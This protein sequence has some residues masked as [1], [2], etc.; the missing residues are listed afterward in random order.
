MRKVAIIGAG[1]SP[2]GVFPD[3]GVKELGEEACWKAIKDANIDPRRIEIAYCGNFCGGITDKQGGV[4]GQIV[5]AQ[6]GITGI[7]ITRVENACASSSCALREAYLVIAGGFYDIAIAFGVEK[8]TNV[9]TSDA[10]RGL[11]SSSDVELEGDMG[12]TFPGVFSL[13]ARRHMHQYGTTREQLAKVAIKN[14][15]NGSLNPYAQFQ[16]EI[17]MEQVLQ[18][19]MIADPLTLFDCCPISD[20]CTAVILAGEDTAKKISD[21]PVWIAASVLATGKYLNDSDIT[22]FEL[23]KRAANEAYEK[24][25]IGPEDINLAEVHDCFT[26]AEICHY[27]DLGFCKKGEGGKFIDEG[28]TQIGGKIPINTSGGLKA[29]GHPVGA[30]GIAQIIEIMEQLREESGKRQVEGARVGLAHC[31][32]GFTHGD[33]ASV[34]IH[35]LK[36]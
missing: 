2:F 4:V 21:K 5:L 13:I 28:A 11:V 25:G 33:G 3:Q 32:G 35:I 26:I 15:K 9:P 31:M 27:E 17:T 6:V 18:S 16:K 29:K 24:A 19:P 7:P 34:A 8:M 12:L 30:T 36:K 23:N 14:H 10:I 22:T 20:G 1:M